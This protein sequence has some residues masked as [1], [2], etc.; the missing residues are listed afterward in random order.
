MSTAQEEINGF[1]ENLRKTA[2]IRIQR[3]DV[4]EFLLDHFGQVA[5]DV[6]QSAVA[7]SAVRQVL[8]ITEQRDSTSWRHATQ[9]F[10]VSL[11]C[12]SKRLL[13]CISQLQLRELA[14]LQ[15]RRTL[16]MS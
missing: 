12:F 9:R 8:A 7:Q 14:G 15:L 10:Q 5:S 13:S 11:S 2:R 1:C 4:P 3:P 6:W 16:R